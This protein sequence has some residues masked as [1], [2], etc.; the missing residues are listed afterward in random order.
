M[1]PKTGSLDNW[2]TTWHTARDGD[3]GV[4]KDSACR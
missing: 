1:L 4:G 3:T 2:S